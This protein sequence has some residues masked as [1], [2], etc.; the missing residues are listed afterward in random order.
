VTWQ[1]IWQRLDP[2]VVQR[3][4][5]AVQRLAETEQGDVKRLQ[6][7]DPPTW[8]LRVGEYRVLFAYD[9]SAHELRVLRVVPRGRA[10]RA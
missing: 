8:R 7:V 2:R 6:G 9:A 4:G 3:I 1:V 5:R 10:Y